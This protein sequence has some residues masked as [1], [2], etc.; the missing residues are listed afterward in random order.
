MHEVPWLWKHHRL[1]HV[2]K[3]PNPLLSA[4]AS[5][6][7]DWGDILVIPLLTWAVVR[8]DFTTWFMANQM[9]IWTEAF[10]HSGVRLHWITP[11]TG[12]ILRF[13]DME[14]CLED[15]DLHHRAGWRNS[16]NYGKQTRVWDKLFRSTRDRIECTDDNIDWV[17]T[18]RTG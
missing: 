15:H 14:L 1:H 11:M 5:D 9:I 13:F 6:E 12:Y 8:F 7:Q 17:N 3:H 2:T 16:A 18:A 4:F 10:G